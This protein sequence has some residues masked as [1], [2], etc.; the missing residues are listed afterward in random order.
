MTQAFARTGDL[1]SI[2]SYPVWLQRVVRETNRDKA[3]VVEHE[4]F[5]LMRDARLTGPVAAIQIPQRV[6]IGY[7]TCWVSA[8]ELAQQRTDLVNPVA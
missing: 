4:L 7:H 3:R 6:P 8:A 1:K 2:G 5:T